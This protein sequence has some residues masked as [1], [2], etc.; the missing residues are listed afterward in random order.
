MIIV[1]DFLCGKYIFLFLTKLDVSTSGQY[2]IVLTFVLGSES[3]ILLVSEM[4]IQLQVG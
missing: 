1:Y 3:G 2:Q 4:E